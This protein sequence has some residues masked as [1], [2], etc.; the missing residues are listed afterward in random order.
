[1][2]IKNGIAINNKLLFIG[3][4]WARLAKQSLLVAIDTV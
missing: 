3:S 2:S 4:F 1:M